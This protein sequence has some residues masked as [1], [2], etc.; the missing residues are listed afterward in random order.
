VFGQVQAHSAHPQGHSR[1]EAEPRARQRASGAGAENRPQPLHRAAIEAELRIVHATLTRPD[2]RDWTTLVCGNLGVMRVPVLALSLVLLLLA[3]AGALAA[4]QPGVHVDPGS[5]A[6]HQYQIPI[7]AA[8]SEAAGQSAAGTAAQS[9]P[10]FGVG[11][12]SSHRPA[13]ADASSS[14]TSETAAPPATTHVAKPRRRHPVRPTSRRHHAT[15]AAMPASPPPPPSEAVTTSSGSSGWV[16]LVL[17][18]ALVL[19]LGGA[20]GFALRRRLSS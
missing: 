5:P 3:P 19:V 16:A 17:G 1:G 13:A 18:G 12:T 10:A 15:A 8:R 4:T 14:P 2:E 7:P 20:G 11:I 9:A 6:S